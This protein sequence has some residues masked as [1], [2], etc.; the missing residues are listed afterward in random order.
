MFSHSVKLVTLQGFDVKIDPS[1][2]LI[3][4]LITWS[5]SSSYFPQILPGET[6]ATYLV[7][8]VIAML[9]FF[10]SLILHELAHSIVARQ[11]GVEMRGITLFIF[12]GVAE[13]ESEPK[14]PRSEFLI[15]SAGPLMSFAL[16]AGFWV[17]SWL[18]GVVGID[19]ALVEVFGYLA[20]VNIILAIF[21]LLPAFPLDG[22]RVFRAYLWGRSKNLIKA[23][24]TA[25]RVSSTIAYVIIGL[26]VLSL[27]SNGGIG[28]LWQILIG[29][30]VLAAARSTYQ[31]QFMKRAF[32]GKTV[33]SLISAQPVTATPDVTLSEMV[34]QIML[35]HRVSFVPVIEDGTLLGYVDGDVLSGIDR[36]NWPGTHV[37][38]V[39]VARDD[40][41]TV[42]RDMAIEDLLKRIL[43]SQRRKYLVTHDGRLHGVVTLAD[44]TAYLALVDELHALK[45][46]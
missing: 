43:G 8:S 16:G 22:G 32:A 19:T 44:L 6:P 46:S 26:G 36:E 41:N 24:E 1:W 7:L 45:A 31:Q 12:G 3:A 15:A 35:R 30:F 4:A 34:N 21:N 40:D 33:G 11:H 29:L 25:T 28:A 18:L 27:F 9:A 10:M 37:G 13:M 14:T 17:I 5:L 38:D 20:L 23:T 39:F 2:L 42:D